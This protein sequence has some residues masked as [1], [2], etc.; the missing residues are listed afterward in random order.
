MDVVSNFLPVLS[1]LSRRKD[2][3]LW[4]VDRM[5]HSS[6]ETHFYKRANFCCCFRGV[7]LMKHLEWIFCSLNDL[8]WNGE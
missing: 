7:G 4:I 5:D 6:M 8:L 1:M 2:G 3:E